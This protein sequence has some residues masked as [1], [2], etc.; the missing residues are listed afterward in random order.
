MAPPSLRPPSPTSLRRAPGARGRSAPP[1]PRPAPPT[2]PL[3]L[4]RKDVHRGLHVQMVGAVVAAQAVHEPPHDP[5]RLQFSRG[6]H[7]DHRAL[8]LHPRAEAPVGMPPPPPAPVCGA[9]ATGRGGAGAAEVP[10]W[11]RGLR[12]GVSRVGHVAG[13]SWGRVQGSAGERT[14]PG[15]LQVP[16]GGGSHPPRPTSAGA[17][18]A[19]AHTSA[20][21]PLRSHPPPV[22]TPS[23]HHISVITPTTTT[24]AMPQPQPRPRFEGPCHRG[25]PNSLWDDQRHCDMGHGRR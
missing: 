18:S 5:P 13:E 17:H 20:A 1:A 12:G 22:N 25:T 9:R 14:D 8:R 15:P 23:Q 11:G 10:M 6:R 19:M 16:G 21:Q 4:R 3:L 2:R 24:S 7:A